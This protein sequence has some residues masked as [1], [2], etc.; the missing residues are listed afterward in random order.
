LGLDLRRLACLAILAMLAI[1]GCGAPAT[2]GPPASPRISCQGVPTERCDEA[3]ASVGLSLPNTTPTAIEVVCVSGTCTPE[4]G[5]MDTVVTLADGSQLRSTTTTWSQ[6]AAV[7]DGA[8]PVPV[9][10]EPAP[11]P[12]VIAPV[13]QGV[14]KSMCDTLAETAFGELSTEAVVSILVR[15]TEPPCTDDH[16]VGE[17][18]VSYADGTTGTSSWEYEGG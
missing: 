10:E 12:A 15:C 1:A 13:C 2:S 14:P 8:K 17:T 16:G 6:G 11:A 5:A 7:P 4:S 9:L 3:V 18:L